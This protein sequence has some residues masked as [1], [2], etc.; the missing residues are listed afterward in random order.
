MPGTKILTV[1]GYKGGT[2]KSTTAV[3][4]AAYFSYYG[5]TVLIAGDP[6]RTALQW[7]ER[8]ALPFTV[9]TDKTAPRLTPGAD[10]LILDRPARPH[11]K[12]LQELAAG[13]DLLILPTPPDVGS[14]QS[15]HQM[16]QAIEGANYRALLTL[17]APRPSREG[18]L[19]Y[20]D[21]KESGIPIFETMIRRAAQ[22]G[23][24]ALEGKLIKDLAEDSAQGA[25]RDYV[26]LGD[27]IRGLIE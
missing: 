25:W 26:S 10:F 18:D 16:T 4:L 23:Q 6:N 27:E 20:S 8:G 9:A 12:D 3:H 14:L 7:S 11:S 15:L 22:F 21:L 19:R 2:A 1:T 17:V 5:R 24:A 13:C